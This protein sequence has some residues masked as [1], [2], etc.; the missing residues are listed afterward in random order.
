MKITICGAGSLGH[1]C[2]GV[3]SSQTDVQVSLLSGHPQLWHKTITVTD[4][5]ERT[6]VGTPELISSNPADVIPTADIVLFCLPGYLI[7]QTLRNI[8]PYLQPHTC[9]GSIVSSTGFFFFAHEILPAETPLFGFQ[10]VP[11]IARVGEYGS[12]ARLLGYKSSLAVA[13]ENFS[14]AESFRVCVEQLFHTP[15]SLLGS[16]YEAALTNSNPIL[17]TGRLFTMWGQWDG[18]PF[19]RC[20]LFYK[21]WDVASA[22]C[23]IDMDREFMELLGHLPIRKGSIPS[24]LEYYKQHDAES[25]AKKLRSITAFQSILSPMKQLSD[26]KWIPDFESRYFTEDFPFG[27]RFIVDLSRKYHVAIPVID[28]VYA[29]GLSKCRTSI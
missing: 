25:L 23:L 1:V 13:C 14:N 4:E 15:T 17:H 8:R 27:L 24:L 20:S 11:F 16:F 12:S 21:E 6:F 7:E 29:W 26:G 5:E 28:K 10:R 19:E 9:V 18:T 22:Q 2:L 3:L